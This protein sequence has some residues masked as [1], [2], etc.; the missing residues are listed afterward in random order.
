M[1]THYGAPEWMKDKLA[2]E[3]IRRNLC[4]GC[5]NEHKASVMSCGRVSTRDSTPCFNGSKHVCIFIY[6][7]DEAKAEYVARRLES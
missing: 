2:V 6:N 7:T 5:V 1:I 3:P 4:K